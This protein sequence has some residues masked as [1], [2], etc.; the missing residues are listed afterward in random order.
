M[1]K[2]FEGQK[3]CETNLERNQ[4]VRLSA[5]HLLLACTKQWRGPEV[6]EW[7]LQVYITIAGMTKPVEFRVRLV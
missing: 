1:G 3:L 6:D 4:K 2:K 7:V 5:E